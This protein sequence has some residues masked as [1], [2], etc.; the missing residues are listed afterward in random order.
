MGK[1]LDTPLNLDVESGLDNKAVEGY[2]QMISTNNSAKSQQIN[3]D[4]MI[5]AL[6]KANFE[7]SDPSGTQKLNSQRLY[8]AMWRTH[9]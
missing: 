8:Q 5:R 6:M 7:I 9:A 4:D 3:E 2:L 1:E